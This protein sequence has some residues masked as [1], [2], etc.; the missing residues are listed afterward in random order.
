[1]RSF[2]VVA[3]ALLTTTGAYAESPTKTC[4]TQATES[5]LTGTSLD[6]FMAKCEGEAHVKCD[7]AAL[8]NSLSGGAKKT[9]TKK[10]VAEAVGA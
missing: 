4:R 3:V 6:S 2:L 5:K 10:C 1:M 7:S 8:K 9:F